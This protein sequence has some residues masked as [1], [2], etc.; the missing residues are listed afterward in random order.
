[1]KSQF[2]TIDRAGGTPKSSLMACGEFVI[3]A[4]EMAL[5]LTASGFLPLKNCL[6]EQR[7]LW[8]HAE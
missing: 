5:L 3:W 1:M 7:Y 2:R 6:Q 4:R 8:L